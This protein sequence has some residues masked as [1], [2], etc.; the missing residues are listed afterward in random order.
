MASSAVVVCDLSLYLA[1]LSGMSGLSPLA[2]VSS[3]SYSDV[4]SYSSSYIS[5]LSLVTLH[6]FNVPFSR[7]VLVASSPVTSQLPLLSP[8]HS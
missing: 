1:S 8:T 5:S 6:I 2:C 7:L 4:F 3:Q